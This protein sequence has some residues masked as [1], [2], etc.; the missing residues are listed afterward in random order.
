MEKASGG[1]LVVESPIKN[2]LL[3]PER[4]FCLIMDSREKL[5]AVA[6]CGASL[7]SS[8]VPGWAQPNNIEKTAAFTTTIGSKATV[9]TTKVADKSMSSAYGSHLEP[10]L[11]KINASA[12]QRQRITA[13]VTSYK[14]K[15]EPLRQEYREKSQQ[16][17]N[18]L[19][20]GQP[21]EAVMERQSELNKI[22]SSIVTQYGMMQLEI[23][24]LLTP[25]QAKAF[26]EYKRSQGWNKQ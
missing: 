11:V 25:Q 15:I 20:S 1:N 7:L 13:I 6:L 2:L 10:I 26:E 23:R 17:V 16:F 18:G 21:A 8:G 22:Y 5:F 19:V 9:T 12:D 14:P 24:K 4:G 3:D